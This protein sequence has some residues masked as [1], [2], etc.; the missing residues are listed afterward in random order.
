[1]WFFGESN[2]EI[3]FKIQTEYENLHEKFHEIEDQVA[4]LFFLCKSAIKSQFFIQSE[5]FSNIFFF[6]QI[7]IKFF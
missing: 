2:R 1:M 4:K 6:S 7:F 3:Y 5:K